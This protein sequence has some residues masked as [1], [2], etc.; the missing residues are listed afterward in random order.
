MW[1]NLSE[2]PCTRCKVVRRIAQEKYLLKVL[3]CILQ[4][5]GRDDIRTEYVLSVPALF[6]ML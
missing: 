6:W 4:V 2:P 3:I 5:T 1:L